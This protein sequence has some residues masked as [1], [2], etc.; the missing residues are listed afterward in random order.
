MQA[1]KQNGV[2]I[3]QAVLA[4]AG[5]MILITVVLGV[6]WTKWALA[7]T[8]F[9]GANMLQAAFTGF[10][11]AAKIF[12]KFGLRSGCAFDSGK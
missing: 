12:S 1:K 6:L 8:A 4:M 7:F 2:N 11:P 5:T 10:C 3:D 9:V